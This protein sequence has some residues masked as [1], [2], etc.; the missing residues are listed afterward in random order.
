MCVVVLSPPPNHLIIIFP[1]FQSA[2]AGP[3]S[4]LN[5]LRLEE[6]GVRVCS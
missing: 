1:L 5:V 2:Q 4:H 3:R 6:T